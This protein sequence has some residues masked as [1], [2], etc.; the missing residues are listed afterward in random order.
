MVTVLDWGLGHAGRSIPLIAEL[1]QQGARVILAS[2]GRA[3]YLLRDAYPELTYL[4]CPAYNVHYK[5]QNMYWNIFRQLPKIF[6]ATFREHFWLRKFVQKN[7]VD[8]VISDSRFGCFH[9]SIPSVIITHQLRLR[10]RPPLLSQAVNWCYRLLLD[11]FNAVWVPDEPNGLSGA[12]SYPSPFSQTTYLGGLSRFQPIR[13]P[14]RYDLLVLLSG[15]EPQRTNLER[16]VL[17]Q[18]R[19][20]PKLKV[21]VVQGKTDLKEE[22][23]LNNSVRVVS[24]L[25]GAALQEAIAAAKVVLCRSGYSSLMDLAAMGKKAI[26]VPTP[27]QPE[28]EYLARRCDQ[29][30]WA[31]IARQDDL[32]IG[33]ALQEAL[34]D[35]DKVGFRSVDRVE[36]LHSIVTQFLASR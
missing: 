3:G 5:G 10:I 36:H 25:S 22:Q 28:Q 35:Y 16:L 13:C 8:A 7:Q 9:H 29:L 33:K 19:K 21:L 6:W 15:P 26:L 32:E 18:L 34:Q 14:V 27:G 24:Y 1:K 20:L 4:E 23:K 17:F 12:L 2:S 31:W 30:G 11:R